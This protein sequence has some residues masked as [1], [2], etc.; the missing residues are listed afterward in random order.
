[1]AASVDRIVLLVTG[2]LRRICQKTTK[3]NT[4]LHVDNKP[5]LNEQNN[6]NKNLFQPNQKSSIIYIIASIQIEWGF[7][8]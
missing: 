4:S 2:H 5:Y 3:Q 6:K 8:R 1:M 7:A